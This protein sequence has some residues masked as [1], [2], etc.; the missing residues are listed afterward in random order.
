MDE[1]EFI[2]SMPSATRSW[3]MRSTARLYAMA[4]VNGVSTIVAGEHGTLQFGPQ[5][6]KLR[7]ALDLLGV[8]TT[9]PL[10]IP[11]GGK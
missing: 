3:S 9:Q 1:I 7:M 11:Y 10:P 4:L 2:A 6:A 8:D 5:M